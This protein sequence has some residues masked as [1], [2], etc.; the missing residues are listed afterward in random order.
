MSVVTSGLATANWTARLAAGAHQGQV[1][2]VNTF[3]WTGRRSADNCSDGVFG[4]GQR[5]PG[6]PGCRGDQRTELVTVRQAQETYPPLGGAGE[7]DR[8][9][10]G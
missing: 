6:D 10:G 5:R 3:T 9:G 7:F 8:R 2:V 4:K 1:G